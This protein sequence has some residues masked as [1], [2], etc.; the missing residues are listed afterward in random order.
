[1]TQSLTR[2]GLGAAF[3]TL[4]LAAGF[5]AAPVSVGL[6]TAGLTLKPQAALA[7]RGADD[8]AGHVRQGRGADD[9]AGHVRQGR[10]AD[11]P[12]GDDRGGNRGGGADDHGGR[13]GDDHGGNRG[14]GEGAGHR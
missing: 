4:T 9:P 7:R 6:G 12:A 13:G 8:P 14:G 11:D 5:A 3:A 10:G 2:R 1:M